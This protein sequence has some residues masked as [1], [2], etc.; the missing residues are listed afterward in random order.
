MFIHERVL[1]RHMRPTNFLVGR[2][3]RFKLAGF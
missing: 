1:H 2:E 3:L